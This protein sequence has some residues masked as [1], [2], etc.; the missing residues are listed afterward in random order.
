M[1]VPEAGGVG[2][3]EEEDVAPHGGEVGEL[4]EAVQAIRGALLAQVLLDGEQ[5]RAPVVGIFE[6]GEQLL[7]DAELLRQGH[8]WGEQGL[9]A[10]QQQEGEQELQGEE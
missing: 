3:E 5:E 9:A 4:C 6:S 2:D 8:E 7:V 10:P 1:E